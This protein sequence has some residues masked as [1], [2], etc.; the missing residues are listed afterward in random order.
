M[1]T[2]R[3]AHSA[4]NSTTASRASDGDDGGAKRP[5]NGNVWRLTVAQALAGGNAAVVYAT[6]SIVGNTLAPDPSL[7]TLPISI[8][9]VGMALCT[10]PAGAIA[11]R[12][13]RGIVFLAGAA[14]GVLVGV[15]SAL[16]VLFASFW[17][18]CAAT[19]FGG[20]YN[21]VILTFRFAAADGVPA[22]RQA[23]ALSAV[24][25][26]GVFAGILG[27]QL[28]TVTMNLWQPYVF[29]ATFLAQAAVALVAGLVLAGVKVPKPTAVEIAGGRPLGVIVRQPRF[30]AA[31]ICGVVSYTLMNFIMT[32]AP[33][34]M[35]LCGLP[36]ETSNLGIQWHI[37]AM[38][39]PSFFTGRLISRFGAPL[40]IFTGLFLIAAAAAIGLQG[41]EVTHFWSTLVLAG[42]GW[43][44][45]F[46]GASALVLECHRPEERTSVQSFNDFLVFG[47]MTVGS[48]SSGSLLIASGWDAVLWVTFLPVG[49]AV[50]ILAVTTW[51]HPRPARG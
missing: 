11:R 14:C 15:L 29:A 13:G 44:L 7:A 51:L 28:V 32:S 30:V 42:V 20:A 35:R 8:F 37:V 6:G 46:L 50:A 33:L 36:Q 2:A 17:L 41:I 25:A 12:H 43:N 1:R 45:G 16:A 22:E 9:V 21:A 27:P 31:V 18:F 23:R 39:A 4:S 10:L 47:T 38:Y 5:G 19:F 49:M 3:L 34:A 40:V 48:F 24:M 26:G